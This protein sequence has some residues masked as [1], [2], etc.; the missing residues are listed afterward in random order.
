MFASTPQKVLGENLDI[1]I[2]IGPKAG[3]LAFG[4]DGLDQ[5]KSVIDASG[6]SDADIPPVQVNVSL[7]RIF[8]FAAA[9]GDEPQVAALAEALAESEGEDHVTLTVTQITNG[10]RVRLVLEE[11]VLKLVG[12]AGKMS[13]EPAGAGA[14]GF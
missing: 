13:Q 7:G 3:Y 14:G 2:G 5:L 9:K 12:Q 6:K 1:V 8:K 11:G 10:Q 4:E